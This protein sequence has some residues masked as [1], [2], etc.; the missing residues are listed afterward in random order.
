[1]LYRAECAHTSAL[2]DQLTCLGCCAGLDAP[3]ASPTDVA[4]FT[5]Q[6]VLNTV[7]PAVPGIHFLS[8]GM[9]EEESTLNLQ[10]L[11]ARLGPLLALVTSVLHGWHGHS[12]SLATHLVRTATC[13]QESGV[14][15]AQ[16]TE[17]QR[18]DQGCGCL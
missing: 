14:G 3:N 5:V 16:L 11:Q 10:A 4:K 6:T 1:M 13:V 2:A 18:P 7:P 12:A 8:G 17:M 15:T 9:S